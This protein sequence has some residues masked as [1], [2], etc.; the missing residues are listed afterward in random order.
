MEKY[1][2]FSKSGYTKEC[3]KNAGVNVRLIDFCDMMNCTWTT[4][5]WCNHET[6]EV[7]PQLICARQGTNGSFCKGAVSL[8]VAN[9]NV[10]HVQLTPIDSDW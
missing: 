1:Y 2:F 8:R 9:V 5:C 10:V 7:C 4:N 3:Q 6:L